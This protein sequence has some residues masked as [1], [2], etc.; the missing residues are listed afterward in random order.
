M[1][2]WQIDNGLGGNFTE[3]AFNEDTRR[4]WHGWLEAK[5]ETIER[6][7]EQ[8]GLRHWGQ[9]VSAWNQVPMPMAAPTVHNPALVLDWNR[10]CSDT[11]VQFVEMQAE[12]LRELTP[13][14]PVTTNL[15]AAAPPLRPFRPGRT[16]W[17]LSPSKARRPSRPNRRKSP[18]KLTCCAR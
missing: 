3:A 5:Y 10:F 17:I 13:D 7:N 12:M 16:C 4:D 14:R 1:I 8:L 2:A 11:I 15:R 9:V 6:L 18:A